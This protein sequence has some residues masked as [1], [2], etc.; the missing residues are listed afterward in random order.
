MQD[1]PRYIKDME[2]ARIASMAAQAKAK[3]EN[4]GGKR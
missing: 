3:K 1:I 2:A 4:E